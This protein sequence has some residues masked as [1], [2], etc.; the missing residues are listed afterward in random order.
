MKKQL[1]IIIGIGTL[2]VVLLLQGCASYY[3][4]TTIYPCSI[5]CGDKG[6]T[7]PKGYV[8]YQNR[9]M[10]LSEFNRITNQNIVIQ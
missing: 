5:G 4:D 6:I 9:L 8:Y 3:K 2:S 1:K 10:T 7:P